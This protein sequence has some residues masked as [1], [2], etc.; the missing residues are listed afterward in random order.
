MAENYTNKSGNSDRATQAVKDFVKQGADYTK[1]IA[2]KSEAA[3]EA[4]GKSVQQTYST[5]ASDAANFNLQWIEMMRA[6]ANASLDFA[7]QAIEAKS[8]SEFF[9]LSAAHTRNQLEAFVQQVQQLTGLA[10]KASTDA[11]KPMQKAFNKAA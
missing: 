2:E 8:P 10:Q 4:A 1:N 3:V 5:V 11:V 9:Q 6:N 7:R